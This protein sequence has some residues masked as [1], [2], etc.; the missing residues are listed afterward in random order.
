MKDRFLKK[1]K[2]KKKKHRSKSS[3]IGQAISCSDDTAVASAAEN[4]NH[5]SEN[6]PQKKPQFSLSANGGL[7]RFLQVFPSAMV[8]PSTRLARTSWHEVVEHDA[9]KEKTR[10]RLTLGGGGR[11]GHWKRRQSLEESKMLCCGDTGSCRRIQTRVRPKGDRPRFPSYPFHFGTLSGYLSLSLHSFTSRH[12]RLSTRS[13]Y[14][15]QSS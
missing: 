1:K 11:S 3:S 2:K 8:I 12:N 4:L 6:V 10:A 15:I 14:A 13:L 5:D 7:H 9:G